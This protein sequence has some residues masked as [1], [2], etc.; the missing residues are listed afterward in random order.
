ML[1]LISWEEETIERE[2]V[3]WM[4]F[5]SME[6]LAK[7]CKIWRWVWKREVSVGFVSREIWELLTLDSRIFPGS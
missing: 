5:G 4:G 2:T 1:D 7:K 3:R 6:I